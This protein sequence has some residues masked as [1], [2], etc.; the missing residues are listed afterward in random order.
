MTG[1]GTARIKFKVNCFVQSMLT[2]VF[3]NMLSSVPL[4]NIWKQL[5]WWNIENLALL[6]C[7]VSCTNMHNILMIYT[8]VFNH[9]KTIQVTPAGPKLLFK[10]TVINDRCSERNMS[11]NDCPT[12]SEC[13]VEM[14]LS[15]K[16]ILKKYV[17]WTTVNIHSIGLICH[18]G[19][20]FFP[21]HLLHKR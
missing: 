12:N 11:S 8:T 5:V 21:V 1:F 19:T 10:S 14:F 17:I 16:N 20:G 7:S 9:L 2:W 18:N 13:K 4:S 3:I 6:H 15:F